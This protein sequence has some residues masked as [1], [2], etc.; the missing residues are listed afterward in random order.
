M[1]FGRWRWS[2]K[3]LCARNYKKMISYKTGKKRRLLNQVNEVKK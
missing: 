1:E 2:V 3:K